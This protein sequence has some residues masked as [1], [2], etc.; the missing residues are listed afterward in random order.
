MLRPPNNVPQRL[1]RAHSASKCFFQHL[2]AL[3]A[4]GSARAVS[5]SRSARKSWPPTPCLRIAAS[6]KQFATKEATTFSSSKSIRRRCKSRLR[7]HSMRR[8]TFPPYQRKP[9]QAQEQTAPTIDKGH[10]RTKLRRLT[11]TTSWNEHLNGP[12]VE[13]V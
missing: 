3:C 7:P 11:N 10:G 13:Q 4:R 12:Y 2:L 6:L 1:F 5:K 9:K 8:Q